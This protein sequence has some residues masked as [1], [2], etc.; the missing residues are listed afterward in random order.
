MGD[1]RISHMANSSVGV[2]FVSLHSHQVSQHTEESKGQYH[3]REASQ[4]STPGKSY[5]NT[6]KSRQNSYFQYVDNT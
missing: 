2:P 1:S 5:K 3:Q 6:Q 4:F